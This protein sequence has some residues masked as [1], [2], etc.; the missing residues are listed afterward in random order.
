MEEKEYL[1]LINNKILDILDKI[2]EFDNFINPV[3]KSNVFPTYCVILIFGRVLSR[4]L[5]YKEISIFTGFDITTVKKH[6]YKLRDMNLVYTKSKLVKD[7]S[8]G[9]RKK[10]IVY[11]FPNLDIFKK[12]NERDLIGFGNVLLSLGNY[13]L[14]IE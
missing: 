1:D 13:E 10:W 6:V 5:N 2:D 9:G 14:K 7:V 11:V 3:I 4:G 8:Y 12:N